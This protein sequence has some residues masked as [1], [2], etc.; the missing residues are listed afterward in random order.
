MEVESREPLWLKFAGL[1]SAETRAT[2]TELCRG[3]LYCLLHIRE[4]N[5]P[6]MGKDHLKRLKACL[7]LTASWELCL[8]L[9]GKQITSR[10]PRH[11]TEHIDGF[12]L[13]GGGGGEGGN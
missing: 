6:T 9:P 3:F 2:E 4:K 5:Y 11:W 1:S 8:F 7:V 10:F 13:N 12:C